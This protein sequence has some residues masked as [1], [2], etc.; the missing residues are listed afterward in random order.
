MSQRAAVKIQIK[1]LQRLVMANTLGSTLAS[2]CGSCVLEIA[3]ILIIHNFVDAF[4]VMCVHTCAC[5]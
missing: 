5:E 2:P 3:Q 1:H 4:V